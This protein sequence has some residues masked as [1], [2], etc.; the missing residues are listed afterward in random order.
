M[1]NYKMENFYVKVKNKNTKIEPK[2]S[3]DKLTVV[4]LAFW[5]KVN[6]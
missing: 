3:Y 5:I 6:V 2:N 1:L 4:F